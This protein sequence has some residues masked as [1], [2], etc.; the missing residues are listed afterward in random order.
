MYESVS[1]DFMLF[2]Y[3]PKSSKTNK[4]IIFVCGFQLTFPRKAPPEDALEA[5]GGSCVKL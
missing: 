5:L 4:K 2:I 1:Y 3:T